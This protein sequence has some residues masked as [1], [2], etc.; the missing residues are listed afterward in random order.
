MGEVWRP[1]VTVAAVIEREGRFLF[2]EEETEFGVR[3]NQ[4]AGHWEP[5]ESLVDAVVRETLEESRLRFAPNAVVG[6]YHWTRPDGALTY[7]RFAFSGKVTGEE[8][9]RA[10][11]AGI[12]RTLWLLPEEVEAAGRE[13]RLRSPMVLACVRDWREGRR[14]SLDLI[15]YLAG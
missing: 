10:L 6:V 5:G 12:L 14:Y 2:V 1:H 7:L 15:R 8:P 4:P 11:D 13:G 9:D 3:L